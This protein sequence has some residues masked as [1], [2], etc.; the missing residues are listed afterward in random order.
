MKNV[1]IRLKYVFVIWL[2]V[3][4]IYWYVRSKRE[5]FLTLAPGT[6]TIMVD[7]REV[8]KTKLTPADEAQRLKLQAAYQKVKMANADAVMKMS[9]AE[10]N[11]DMVDKQTVMDIA[12]DKKKLG[13]MKLKAKADMV[14][15][16]KEMAAKQ[17]SS[18]EKGKKSPPRA[19]KKYSDKRLKDNLKKIGDIRGVTVYSWT[20]ND[21]A[22][23]TYGNRGKEVGVLAQDLPPDLVTIDTYGYMQVK[24]GTWAANMIDN[25][26]ARY[27]VK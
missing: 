22:M 10:A 15:F 20:W 25:I 4:S 24:P 5:N 27:F 6:E 11:A 12:D 14:Q 18:N 21:I 2:V 9:A 17:E 13:K 1:D 7:G 8:V 16:K 19:T 3:L 26:K 23:S